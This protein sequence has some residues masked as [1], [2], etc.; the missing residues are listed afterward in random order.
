M[1]VYFDSQ[2]DIQCIM[3]WL[4]LGDMNAMPRRAEI[5]LDYITIILE[6]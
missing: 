4:N 6:V 1:L 2:K 3:I 5:G